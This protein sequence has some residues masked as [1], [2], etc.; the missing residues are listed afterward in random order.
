MKHPIQI[1]KSKDKKALWVVVQWAGVITTRP[2]A[3]IRVSSSRR[4]RN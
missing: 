1:V 3:K 2:I 4:P